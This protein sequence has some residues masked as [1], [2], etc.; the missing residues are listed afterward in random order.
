[1][2]PQEPAPVACGRTG[3]HLR[4]RD[5]PGKLGRGQ[6]GRIGRGAVPG[7]AFGVAEREQQLAADL[8]AR[9]AVGHE[10]LDRHPVEAR[11]LLVR[12]EA[13]RAGAGPAGV[14][15]GLLAAC[16]GRRLEEVVRELSE[17]GVEIGGVAGLE[18]LADLPMELYPAT[19]G[20]AMVRGVPDQGVRESHASD[21]VGHLRD[22]AD[23]D[24][25]VE[26]LEDGITLEPSDAGQRIDLELATEYRAEGE[27]PVASIRE[28]AQATADH[29]SHALGNRQSRRGRLAK[30][31][32][33]GQQPQDLADEQW[34][35]FGLGM[36]QRAQ[37]A[38]GCARRRQLDEALDVARAE[39]GERDRSRD[40][41]ASQLGE[42]GSE[43]V[44][45]GRID[46]AIRA[47]DQHAALTELSSDEPE[48]QQ[49]G[50]VGSVQV[51]EYHH[52]R[53]R[54]RHPRQER[55]ERIEQAKTRS[56]RLGCRCRR[57]IGEPVAQL[58][59][60]PSHFGRSLA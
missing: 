32:L 16:A 31:S 19:A 7:S 53:L 38:R 5:R 23:L 50:L 45:D 43:R 20:Q 29:L 35:A 46:V 6:E 39:A 18:D 54:D 2:R 33:R 3:E 17:M 58:R 52:Q 10:R 9:G 42:G 25:L 56:L 57:Q 27:Q 24:R 13:D 44:G 49:R 47:D 14:V 1:M 34:I 48:Q 51:V 21:H 60:H 26:Q 41:L 11:R 40:R 59:K 12:E 37:F 55:R 8:G 30:A 28:V 22:D 15:C 4:Q 36:Q